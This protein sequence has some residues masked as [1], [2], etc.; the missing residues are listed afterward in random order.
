M[1]DDKMMEII[2]AAK[3]NGRMEEKIKWKQK[4]LALCEEEEP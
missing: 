3:N 2:E 1:L 4:I